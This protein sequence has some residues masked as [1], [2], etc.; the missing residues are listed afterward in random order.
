LGLEWLPLREGKQ[1][2][3]NGGSGSSSECVSLSATRVLLLL[4]PLHCGGDFYFALL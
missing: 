2:E 3:S 1:I 4:L